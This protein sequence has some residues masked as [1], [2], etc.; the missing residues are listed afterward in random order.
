MSKLILK[1]LKVKVENKEV[2]KEISYEF[3]V[4]KI[5][6]IIGA[7]GAGKSS[8]LK[9]IAGEQKYKV[10]S[11]DIFLDKENI[12]KMP[13]HKRSIKG[14]YSI[15]QENVELPGVS[16]INLLKSALVA[17]GK[18]VSEVA[19]YAKVL[20]ECKKLALDE[21][22]LLRSINENFSGGEKKRSE[23]VQMF[24][25]N[26]KFVLLDEIDS[27]LDIDGIKLIAKRI[28]EERKNKCFIIVSHQS[29]IFDFIKLDHVLVIKDGK[30]SKVGNAD[31]LTEKMKKGFTNE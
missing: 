7:N 1:N 14:I 17:R 22:L 24:V 3:E 21:E 5:Y 29:S 4:G 8:L 11:G 15:L 12:L 19:L 18:E 23:L 20:K 9:T 6:A 31:L 13:M 16:M 30:L 27:G 26:P 25:L 2:L 10:T 28:N